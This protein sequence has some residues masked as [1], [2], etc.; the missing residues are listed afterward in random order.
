MSRF[1]PRRPSAAVL[2]AAV[3]LFVSLGGTGYAAFSL[4]KNSVGTKQ[5]RNNAVTTK[6]L[7]NGAVTASKIKNGAV[8]ASK[9]KNGAVTASKINTSGLTVPTANNAATL[10]GLGPSDYTTA[11]NYTQSSTAQ[12]IT[13]TVAT[14][15]S[16]IQIT[17]TGTRRVIASAAVH[18]T[19][20]VAGTGVYLVCHI[21][22]DGTSG[23]ND[24][25]YASP[26]GGFAIVD[27]SVSP[28]A[29]AVVGAGTHTV[30]VLCDAVGGATPHATVVDDA[31]AT[32]AVSG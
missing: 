12:A 9:I 29:S 16:P 4:P 31:L 26:A 14:I 21:T 30:T 23:V 22:I 10:G 11:S 8:T 25:D 28:L 32:W 20:G 19:N 1:R 18:A 5:L 6:K 13:A 15:G 27:A 17:T 7:K 3:A 24:T 2:I